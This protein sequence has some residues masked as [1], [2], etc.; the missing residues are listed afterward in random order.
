MWRPA[1]SP[2]CRSARGCI[3]S[4]PSG[5]CA[6]RRI[7]D[8]PL[9]VK[10]PR[11]HILSPDGKT[12]AFQAVGRIWVMDYPSGTPR[13]LT[14]ESFAPYEYG[15]AWSPDGRSIA[16]TSW[17]DIER[18]HVYTVAAGGGA[19]NRVT[20]TAGEYQEP[21]WTP[22]GRTILVAR[23]SGATARGQGTRPERLLG[24]GE[25]ARGR[26]PGNRARADWRRTRPRQRGR[27]TGCG[28]V[29]HRRGDS[30]W[31]RPGSTAAIVG[32]TCGSPTRARRWSRPMR[33]GSRSWPA[34][35]AYVTPTPP[36]AFGGAVPVETGPAGLLPVTKLSTAGGL[37]VRWRDANTVTYGSGP[38][39]VSW[40]LTTKHADTTTI[41]L[42]VPR[43]IPAGTIA[44]TNAR[45]LTMVSRQ[46]IPHGTIVVKA[47]RITC[48][49]SCSASGADHVV[50]V[51]RPDGH[52]GYRG[53]ACPSP[54]RAG[55]DRAPAQFR[56][57]DLP[58]LRRHH[59]AQSRREL[60]RHVPAGGAGRDRR[61][62][63][64]PDVRDRGN[65]R[66]GGQPGH[67]HI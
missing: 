48:V 8:G 6:S 50:D 63:R 22:D 28:S 53:H 7:S 54:G 49:G 37:F 5:S 10:F 26:R 39:F 40:N 65:I 35:N 58:G 12:L 55:H 57:G 60:D 27:S 34:N 51:E 30:C 4:R 11:W 24:P 20:T 64:P 56:G 29:S 9:E 52:A 17:D 25:P 19:P 31:F 23:G 47:G 42:T 3:A 1:R 2:R 14:A 33:S 15:P 18:G 43:D 13:R 36:T 59:H 32:S 21:S 38:Q 46:V 44:F 41:R 67:Q 16:F 45:I 61:R 66:L 62:D